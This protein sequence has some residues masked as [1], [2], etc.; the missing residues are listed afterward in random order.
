MINPY[1]RTKN[2]PHIQRILRY[3]FE[4]IHK[5]LRGLANNLL[6]KVYVRPR[7]FSNAI[8][9]YYGHLFTESVV[10]VSGWRDG[11]F[12]G[13]TYASYFPNAKS[14]HI[15]NAPTKMKG[16][17]SIENE[18][19]IDLSKPIPETLK[20]KYG[21]VFNHTTIEHIF[22]IDTAIKNLC[23]LS[24]DVVI[25]VAPTLQHIHYNKGYGDYNRLTPMGIVKYLEKNGL[26]TIVLQSN[27]QQ[28]SPIFCFALAVHKDSKYKGMIVKNLDFS[29]G[30]KLFGSGL[31]KVHAVD[32]HEH[33]HITE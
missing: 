12:E 1:S 31:T 19:E 28:F 25:M 18:I 17:G 16:V 14:Y 8:L 4:L 3:F 26:E 5:L 10:N 29:M 2:E 30:G 15:S 20:K 27:E 7:E 22:D 11:D 23:D 13:G 24:T 21:V 6:A 32:I 33:V 9:K